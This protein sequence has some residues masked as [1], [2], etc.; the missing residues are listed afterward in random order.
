MGSFTSPSGGLSGEQVQALIAAAALT[1]GV[2]GTV[3]FTA[4][5]VDQGGGATVLYANGIFTGIAGNDFAIS[6]TSVLALFPGADQPD[7]NYTALVTDKQG[8]VKGPISPNNTW[9]HQ[10]KVDGLTIA[11]GD[12]LSLVILR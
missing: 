4:S 6:A 10:V 3:I 2:L 12:Q 7:V 1:R 11:N 5:D 9:V 8:T